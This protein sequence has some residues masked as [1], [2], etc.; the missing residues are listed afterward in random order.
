MADTSALKARVLLDPR[1]VLG[2]QPG[3]NVS[4]EA[5]ARPNELFAGEVTRVGDVIDP[6][7]RR[8]PAEIELADPKG[9]LLPGL[10]ARFSVETGPAT[11]AITLPRRAVF[12]RF[13]RE[14]VYVIEDGIA[15]RREVTIGPVREGRAEVHDGVLHGEWVIVDGVSRVVDGTPVRQMPVERP[16]AAEEAP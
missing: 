6:D 2:L 13:G 3:A 12:E 10:V 15:R 9:R 16:H 5:F 8:L 14:H 11:K 1:E 7:T 4:V